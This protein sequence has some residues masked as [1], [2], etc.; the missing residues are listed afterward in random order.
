V[1]ITNPPTISRRQYKTSASWVSVAFPEEQQEED[2]EVM[3]L[4]WHS[5]DVA[6]KKQIQQQQQQQSKAKI[7]GSEDPPIS[8]LRWLW[9]GNLVSARQ[10]PFLSLP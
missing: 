2:L 7:W 4:A 8:A 10:H 1:Y 6:H 3:M 9:D 5:R